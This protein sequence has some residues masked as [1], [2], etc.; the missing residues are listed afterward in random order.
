MVATKQEEP[1]KATNSGHGDAY[2]G[3][4]SVRAIKKK[5]NRLEEKT[6][7]SNVGQKQQTTCERKTSSSCFDWGIFAICFTSLYATV[8]FLLWAFLQLFMMTRKDDL[9]LWIWF[10]FQVSFMCVLI[11]GICTNPVKGI[12]IPPTDIENPASETKVE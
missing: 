3:A 7:R 6:S 11:I 8:G 1:K 4:L 5:A 12:I 2:S 10:L 9:I